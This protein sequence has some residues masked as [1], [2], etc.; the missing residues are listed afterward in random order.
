MKQFLRLWKKIVPL[1]LEEYGTEKPKRRR[2]KKEKQ[3]AQIFD[4]HAG[5]SVSV[6]GA[7]IE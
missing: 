1:I 7:T 3:P 6:D 2:A 5:T 4:G